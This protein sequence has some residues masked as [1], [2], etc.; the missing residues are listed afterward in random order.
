M[1]TVLNHSTP[2]SWLPAICLLTEKICE[3]G[4]EARVPVGVM[5]KFFFQNPLFKPVAERLTQFNC[6][7]SFED[8]IKK[9]N[10]FTDVAIFPEGSNCFFGRGEI[11]QPFRS[12]RFIEL[13][14]KMKAKIFIVVHRG[15]ED[16]AHSV[17]VQGRDLPF[18]AYLPG[19]LNEKI[20]QGGFFVIPKI[21]KKIRQFR[22]TCDFYEP[23]ITIDELSRHRG[24]KMKQLWSEAELVRIRMQEMFD[25]MAS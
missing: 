11:I 19:W 5:D 6:F 2:L 22:M 14:L 1:V 15:S 20:Q 21:P 18:Q 12:P 7:P 17:R 9:A 25:S 24:T 16:W 10:D 4:G 8:I 13:A 3:G 23:S